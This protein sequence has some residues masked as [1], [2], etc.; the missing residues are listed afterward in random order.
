MIAQD[1][2]NATQAILS[3]L[4][5]ATLQYQIAVSIIV[6]EPVLNATQAILSILQAATLRY[7]IAVSIIVQ[8]VLN[9]TQA[10][11]SILQAATLQYQI[12]IHMITRAVLNVLVV[13]QSHLISKLVINV[14][15]TA[16]NAP[17]MNARLAILDILSTL[18]L[19]LVMYVLRATT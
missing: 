1:A 18:I 11:L 15:R 6:P 2:L 14:D 7:Q 16:A 19:K 9:A 4:Q 13:M 8:A 10:I 12:A 5:V 17:L 3:I